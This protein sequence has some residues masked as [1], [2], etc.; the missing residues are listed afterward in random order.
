M[1]TFTFKTI[2]PTGKWRAFDNDEIIIKLDKKKCGNIQDKKPHTIR[3]MVN[4]EDINEDG[5]IN[6]PWKWIRLKNEFTSIED[7]KL[8]LKENFEKL[9]KLNLRFS[10]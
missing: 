7:A 3:F 6:C 8:F 2:K 10:E 1:K 4:K 5:N 9:S